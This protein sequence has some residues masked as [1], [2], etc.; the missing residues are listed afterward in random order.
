[1]ALDRMADE[2]VTRK[3]QPDLAQTT[4]PQ[5]PARNVESLR[6]TDG[7][8]PMG[9]V[10]A[11]NA[12]SGFV[13]Q[14]TKYI[15]TEIVAVYIA[16]LALIPAPSWVLGS[17]AG[18]VVQGSATTVT[19]AA[20]GASQ[21]FT[22][23]TQ[24]DATIDFWLWIAFASC[25]I[26]TPLLQ[27]LLVSAKATALGVSVSPPSLPT[28]SPQIDGVHRKR[29]QSRSGGRLKH[30]RKV[31]DPVDFPWFPCV[32]SVIAFLAWTIYLPHSIV[33]HTFHITQYGAALI[34]VVI[35]LVIYTT[36]AA[37]NRYGTGMPLPDTPSVNPN[38]LIAPLQNT[39]LYRTSLGTISYSSNIPD[40]AFDPSA[41]DDVTLSN[42]GFP[43]RPADGP[44]LTRWNALF[45]GALDLIAPT[46]TAIS[47][48]HLSTYAGKD[49]YN[50]AGAVT[51]AGENVF[52]GV[53]A[54]WTMPDVQPAGHGDSH[55]VFWVGLDGSGNSSDVVQAGIHCL[56]SEFDSVTRTL[57]VFVEWYPAEMIVLGYD[58]AF[59]DD[60]Q[61][62]VSVTSP[63]T[64]SVTYCNYTKGTRLAP[65]TLTHQL[66]IPSGQ[67]FQGNVAEWIA[68]RPYDENTGFKILAQFAPIQFTDCSAMLASGHAVTPTSGDAINMAAPGQTPLATASVGTDAS[69][70]C[71]VS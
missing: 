64:A 31:G 4:I 2:F 23:S 41:A 52:N 34:I 59:G 66:D 11:D 3:M 55:V 60:V 67:H 35:S 20:T 48:S 27:Y 61:V 30:R 51:K 29:G 7:Q 16:L 19:D 36:N 49:L 54:R 37:L 44:D 22:A 24:S 15:P 18:S 14:V 9:T 26:I 28:P 58:V 45:A 17:A 68:E 39:V 57:E 40:T 69:V 33:A 62:T 38:P 10:T 1:M 56:V 12:V 70:T 8:S 46:V 25:M 21:Q 13:V 5:Q 32:S 6:S 42:L 63:T 65:L 71:Q 53:T 50:W 47:A 43:V